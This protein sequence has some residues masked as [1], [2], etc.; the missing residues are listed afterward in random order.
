MSQL[1]PRIAFGQSARFAGF[2]DRFNALDPTQIDG[3]SGLFTNALMGNPDVRPET[4]SELEFGVDLGFLDNRILFNATYYVKT[5]DDLLL[6]AQVPASSGFTNQVV[7]AGSLENK[8]LEL[9]I[10]AEVVRTN[11]L[12]WAVGLNLSLIHI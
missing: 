8:G 12:S 5:I 9:G 3:N 7:N 4:Q 10:E 11:D 2:G 6:R 1:K